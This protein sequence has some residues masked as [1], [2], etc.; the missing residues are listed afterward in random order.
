MSPTT[1]DLELKISLETDPHLNFRPWLDELASLASAQCADY[2]AR[3]ALHLACTDELWASLPEHSQA[4]P[5]RPTYPRPPPLDPA[6]GP[7]QRLIYEDAKEAHAAHTVAA[8]KLRKAAIA[9]IGKANELLIANPTHGMLLHTA[10]TV[11]ENLHPI[12]G[13]YT[14]DAIS[15]L[16]LQLTTKLSTIDNF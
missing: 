13:T 3:G 11:I 16:E 15:S 9:S 8:A 12:Y 4:V 5:A 6:A 2:S 7:S 1:S 14:E 10:Q